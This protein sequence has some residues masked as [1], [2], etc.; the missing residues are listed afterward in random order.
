MKYFGN[1]GFA[2][3][4]SDN[5]NYM[6]NNDNN[7]YQMGH[8]ISLQIL[9]CRKGQNIPIDKCRYIREQFKTIGI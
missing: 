5:R 3:D 2:L 6:V 1:W 8:L 7:I 4:N 9:F